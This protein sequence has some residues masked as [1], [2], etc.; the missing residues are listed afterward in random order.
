MF[1]TFRFRG[2][3][4]GCRR[5]AFLLAAIV[6]TVAVWPVSTIASNVPGSY[7]D[8]LERHLMNN[9]AAGV[10]APYPDA[11]VRW[12][13]ANRGSQQARLAV[14]AALP[15]GDGFAWMELGVGIA[16]G[17][18]LSLLLLGGRQLIRGRMAI[19]R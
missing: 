17:G 16:L 10:A 15:A 13:N 7:P 3:E 4:L 1:E 2:P 14:P 6:L 19:T 5:A 12:L 18:T 9:P 11:L 8:A